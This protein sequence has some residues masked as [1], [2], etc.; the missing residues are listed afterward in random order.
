MKEFYKGNYIKD[1]DIE[2]K[3]PR[4]NRFW[5]VG[6]FMPDDDARK[7]ADLGIKFW[8]FNKR[9]K[10]PDKLERRSTEVTLILKGK[11]RGFIEKEVDGSLV[12]SPVELEAGQYVVIPYGVRNN[13][14]EEVVEGPAVG[15]TIKAPNDPKLE[16]Y[17]FP[18]K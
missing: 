4:K 12:R 2:T 10:H 13:L 16:P 11:V 3:D 9:D 18:P 5:I 1:A 7:T 15:I 8:T 17:K 6:H 14:I